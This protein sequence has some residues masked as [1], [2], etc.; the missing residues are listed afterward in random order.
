MIVNGAF[1]FCW[2]CGDDGE[3]MEEIEVEIDCTIW[4]CT[5]H[6]RM[7]ERTE[8]KE[9]RQ[10]QKRETAAWCKWVRASSIS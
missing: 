2:L 9:M 7:R 6:A 1:N 3:D 5:K 10:Q 8:N 4:L